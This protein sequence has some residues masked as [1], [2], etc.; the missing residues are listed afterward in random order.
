MNSRTDAERILDAFLAPEGDQLPDRVL[1]AALGE[2]ARTQQRP[3]LRAPW[4]FRYMPAL[5]RTTA[6]AAAVL[7]AVIGAGGIVYLTNGPGRPNAPT[8]PP[9]ATPARTSAPT[10]SPTATSTFRFD[11]GTWTP[12]TSSVYGFSTAYPPGWRVERAATR[13]WDT[14]FDVPFDAAVS[15]AFDMFINDEGSV[16]IAIWRV[17]VEMGTIV[18]NRAALVAWA[19]EFCDSMDYYEPCAGIADRT[20]QMCRERRDCHPD[21]VIVPFNDDVMAFFVDGDDSLTLAQVLRGDSDPEAA[22]Y[23]GAVHLLQEFVQTMNIFVP[24]PGQ[25]E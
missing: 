25:G 20:I 17:P 9:T 21:A 12:Y 11:E 18:N 1:D 2:I 23:G 14:A 6:M 15:P 24:G 13:P 22:E 4:R 3:A 7:V 10:I 16:A 8:A 19:E 5:S